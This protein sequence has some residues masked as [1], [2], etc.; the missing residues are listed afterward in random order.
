MSFDEGSVDVVDVLISSVG[1][2]GSG[3]GMGPRNFEPSIQES[4]SEYTLARIWT[5]V[6][7]LQR[8]Q[9]HPAMESRSGSC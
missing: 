2:Q 5:E 4:R 9:L 3:T 8:T 7:R 1:F 6:L